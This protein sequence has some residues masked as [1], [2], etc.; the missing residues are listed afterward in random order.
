L[1][2]TLQGAGGIGGLLSILTSDSCL[3]T[4]AFDASG[5]IT[6]LFQVSGLIPHPSPVATYEYGPFGEPLRSTPNSELQ[7]VNPFT[8]STKYTDPE[9]AL[10]YYGHRYYSPSLGRWLNRDPIGEEGGVNRYALVN[11]IPL[12]FVDGL[13]QALFFVNGA[14]R[15][16]RRRGTREPGIMSGLASRWF[17]GLLGQPGVDA[18][19]VAR[20]WYS[21]PF[22]ML[23]GD[24]FMSKDVPT[25]FNDRQCDFLITVTGVRTTG[26]SAAGLR[27]GNVRHMR[28]THS[29]PQF[30][31]I[32]NPTFVD[33]PTSV[34][35]LWQ[36]LNLETDVMQ[37]VGDE[38]MMIGIV[39]RRMAAVVREAYETAHRNRCNESCIR[40]NVVAHSQGAAVARNAFSLLPWNIKQ[41]VFFIGLGGQQ[42]VN[43]YD[44]GGI[45]NI[46]NTHDIVPS[47]PNQPGDLL[48][49]RYSREVFD[50]RDL[51]IP[52]GREDGPLSGHTLD[53]D[54]S[55]D[56]GSYYLHLRRHP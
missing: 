42:Y 5:N 22:D 45:R 33:N 56:D 1:S 31:G 23:S 40:I 39:S 10:L 13:G 15:S 4:P 17:G 37:I 27:S 30:S 7:T 8:F 47:L 35:T 26:V 28:K 6:A 24:V 18:M 44:L 36:G 14:S 38:A 19:D 43:D 11:N 12:E 54:Q 21:L 49:I 50:P 41:R 32:P 34:G 29:L 16:S 25:S 20:V 46:V 9:T 48:G 53:D 55:G 52:S 3:L 51:D 2:G